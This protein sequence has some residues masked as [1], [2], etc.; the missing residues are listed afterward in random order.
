[1]SGCRSLIPRD[2]SVQSAVQEPYWVTFT[3]SDNWVSGAMKPAASADG[4]DE[5]AVKQVLLAGLLGLM[6][7]AAFAHSGPSTTAPENGAVLAAVP[8]HV[9]LT[10]AKRI[11][12]TKVEMTHMSNRPIQLDLADQKAFATEFVV[13]LTGMG[14]GRY[15]IE[16][17]GLGL[18]GHAAQCEFTFRVE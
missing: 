10:F 2:R 14:K 11:R 8:A 4:W 16:W 18:D 13:P 12:L 7:S 3:L 17:R 6:T 5:V 1:M 15:R 9:F